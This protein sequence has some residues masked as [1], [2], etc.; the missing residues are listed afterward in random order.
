MKGGEWVYVSH[1]P[2][3]ADAVVSAVRRKLGEGGDGRGSSP[4]DPTDAAAARSAEA[5][6]ECTL[7]LRF[8]PFI[9]SVEASSVEEA[10]R[11]VAAARD[12]GYRE[13]GITASDK[14]A[15]CSVRC[16]IRMETPV[17]VR[18]ARLVADDALRALVRV[19]NEKWD[20]NARRAE[21]LEE[22]VRA[23]FGARRRP[24]RR[25]RDRDRD[26]DREQDRDREREPS[27]RPG[28]GGGR[29]A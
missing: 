22:R 29:R 5:D 13:S 24:R 10:G 7:V 25:D 15:V 16:S 19:A 18:G 26:R 23:V 11:F 4:S 2:A 6:P 27:A 3:D 20:A 8:E 28:V 9:L 21:R 1:D 14:R 12:A 17:V